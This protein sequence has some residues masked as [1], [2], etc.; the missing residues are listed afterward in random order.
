MKSSLD[1][2][3]EACVKAQ[4]DKPWEELRPDGGGYDYAYFPVPC[5]LADVLLAMNK[6]KHDGSYIISD[7]GYFAHFK[8]EGARIDKAMRVFECSWN[9]HNDSL[10]SQSKETIDFIASLLK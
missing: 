6:L 8:A 10:E 4:P 2:V 3:R 5:R 1:L 9:L 7:A